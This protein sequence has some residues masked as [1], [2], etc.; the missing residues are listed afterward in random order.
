M[1]EPP[2][3]FAIVSLGCPKNLVDAEYICEQLFRVGF[4]METSPEQADLVIVNTCAFLIS[5]VDESIQTLLRFIQEGKEVVCTGCLVSRYREELR[6]EMPEI[7][8]FAGPGTYANLPEAL[9]KNTRFLP[10]LFDS[11]VQRTF[12]STGAYAYVKVSEGCS[13]H[14]HYCL[15][16]A[17]RGELV[18]KPPESILK[19][20]RGL[21]EAGVK[22]LILIG[23]DLGSYGKDLGLSDGLPELLKGMTDIN[24]I[25]WVRLMYMH[26]ASLRE[27]LV[28]IIAEHPK[29]C[30]YIDMPIQHIA[31]KV[32]KAM[33]RKGGAEAVHRALTMLKGHDIWIRTT[34]MVGHP[35]EDNAAFQALEKFVAQEHIDSLGVFEYSPEPNTVS[36]SL[37]QIADDVKMLRR[38]RIMSQQ[39]KNSQTR[40]KKLIGRKLKVLLEGYHAETDLLLQA[41]SEFQAPDV[42]GVVIVNK[43]SAPLG[44][45]A[46]AEITG[47]TDYDLVG[48]IV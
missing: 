10:P 28:R 43:G 24:G 44:T 48:R 42:D 15:I 4:S 25:T 1:I 18:S 26:P 33:G 27:S 31:D 30:S 34:L 19:E 45:M 17:L 3:R 36:A 21:A 41:R 14:C 2:K 16:P 12:V 40:L 6:E 7:R 47:C 5:S 20:C 11:V 22:E 37:P 38:D 23:Q 39:K 13:N 8:L 29:I 9:K 32:L 35:A 46:V